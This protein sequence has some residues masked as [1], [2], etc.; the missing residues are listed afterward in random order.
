MSKFRGCIDLHNGKVKQIV[1]GSL[2]DNS[3]QTNFVSDYN[4][5]YYANLYK[6]IGIQGCHVIKLGPGCDTE[7]SEA[8]NEWPGNLQVGGGINDSNCE[9][10]I[11][12]GASHVIVTSYLFPNGK[13]ELN[14]LES[15]SQ[16]V[17]KERLV[18]DLS[19]RKTGSNSWTVA[20]DK[21]QTL[22]DFIITKENLNLVQDYC[23][24]LLVHAAD[25]E[26]L[27]KGIDED[28]VKQLSEWIRIPC[29]YAGGGR[30]VADLELI[31]RISGGR[32]DLTIGSALDIFGG[33]GITLKEAAEWN[34]NISN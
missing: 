24:E 6:T 33:S 4:A 20:M 10:W 5:R 26:G 28:L 23:A 31:N 7:A 22:T 27:C 15:L 19:C 34:I 25:V 29:T 3:A 9:Y 8:L 16:K 18:V 2:I 17:G 32:V 11:Q 13:F 21:W 1:G 14:R 30:G 12:Q